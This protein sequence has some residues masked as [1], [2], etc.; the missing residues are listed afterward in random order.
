MLQ[1]KL[2]PTLTLGN[3]ESNTLL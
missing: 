1:M 3:S 2:F